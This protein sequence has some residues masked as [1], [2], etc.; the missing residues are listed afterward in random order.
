MPDSQVKIKS[1][2]NQKMVKTSFDVLQ[3]GL[4]Q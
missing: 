2:E 3:E 1:R 4:A